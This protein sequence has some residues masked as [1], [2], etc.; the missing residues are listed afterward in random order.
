MVN[1][2]YKIMIE[3][4]HWKKVL[5]I[6]HFLL[7]TDNRTKYVGYV[8]NYGGIPVLFLNLKKMKKE[9]FIEN[10]S[11]IFHELGHIKCRTYKWT[12]KTL[13]KNKIKSEILAEAF[14]V[15]QIKKYFPKAYKPY[16][17]LWQKTL[18]DE[19]WKRRFPIHYEAFSKI[20]D[21]KEVK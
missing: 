20:K 4:F 10:I 5:R 8:S 11:T 19:D 3:V 18:R 2:E 17:Q 6:P 15:K 9:D 21:F 13:R 1:L 14:A 12:S 7:G 16:V